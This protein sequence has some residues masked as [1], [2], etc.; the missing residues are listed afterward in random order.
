MAGLVPALRVLPSGVLRPG[1][2]FVS[3]LA[4]CATTSSEPSS[5]SKPAQSKDDSAPAKPA[6][7]AEL[8]QAFE[9]ICKEPC[10][11]KFAR[12]VVFRDAE[13]KAQRIRYDGDLEVCSH[14]PRIY[15]DVHGNTV[16]GIPME[17]V[18]A[19][20]AEE[21]GRKQDAIVEGLTEAESISCPAGEN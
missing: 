8:A 3:L 18:T 17:P 6:I 7:P 12:S 1:L 16:L 10:Q 20:V 21:I 5:E 11:G 2:V 13:G 19:E 4:G 9:T 15:F 14:P